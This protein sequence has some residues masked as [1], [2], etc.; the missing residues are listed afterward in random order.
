MSPFPGA[1]RRR[2]R[3]IEFRPLI[4]GA[5]RG[6]ASIELSIGLKMFDVPVLISGGLA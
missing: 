3:L 2:L 6:L 4:K 1:P 5:L